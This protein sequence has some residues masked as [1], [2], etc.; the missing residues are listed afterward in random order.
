M[1][2][3][4]VSEAMI[5]AAGKKYLYQDLQVKSIADYTKTCKNT[6]DLV[7]AADVLAY[8]GDLSE[9]MGQVQSMYCC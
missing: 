8:I 4:D 9:T 6:F 3:V 7:V 2:G 1:V 5:L